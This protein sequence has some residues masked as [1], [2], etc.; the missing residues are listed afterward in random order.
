MPEWIFEYYI[1]YQR[2][3]FNAWN[4]LGPTGYITILSLVGVGGWW[5]MR[6]GPRSQF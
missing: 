2:Y 1:F 5:M 6:K 3:L 4:T